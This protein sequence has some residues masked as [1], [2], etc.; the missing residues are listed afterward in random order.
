MEAKTRNFSELKSDKFDD[1]E[2]ETLT[3]KEQ[4]NLI[5]MF[6]GIY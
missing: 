6:C 1:E 5:K 3:S 2:V 4:V